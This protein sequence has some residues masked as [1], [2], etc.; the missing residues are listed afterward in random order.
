M[1]A[2]RVPV[3]RLAAIAC[4][5]ALCSCS[6]S[7]TPESASKK[8]HVIQVGGKELKVEVVN[9]PE[10]RRL[11]L[12][13]RKTI[14]PD[15]GMLFVYP[16]DEYQSFWMKN[17]YVPLSIAFIRSDGWITQIEDMAPETLLSH[18]SKVRVAFVLEVPQGWFGRNGV[19]L[20]DTVEIPPALREAVE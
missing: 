13:N 17:T 9:T 12:S 5:M 1:G 2:P 4:A 19:K 7:K 14:P 6:A 18:R 8:L 3:H 11:G 10:T 16:D 15:Q 20:G